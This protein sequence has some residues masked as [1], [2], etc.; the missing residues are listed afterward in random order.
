SNEVD[1]LHTAGTE[2]DGPVGVVVAHRRWDQEAPWQ[3]GVNHYLTAGIEFGD[4]AT[5]DLRIGDGVVV[6]VVFELLRGSG[7]VLSGLVGGEDIHI[8]TLVHFIVGQTLDYHRGLLF[9]D[10]AGG[11]GDEVFRVLPELLEYSG[12]Y[13]LQYPGCCLAGQ[14]G[15]FGYLA[16]QV[17]ADPRM[18]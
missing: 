12:L 4:K 7:E 5:L 3:L 17:I 2:R 13:T 15:V 11:L 10:Q 18:D 16:E 1:V 8:V 9:G 14:L 6:D